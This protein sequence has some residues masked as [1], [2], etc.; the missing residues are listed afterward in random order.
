MIF[1]MIQHLEQLKNFIMNDDLVIGISGSGNS[2]NVF[3]RD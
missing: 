1:L 2:K 3:K